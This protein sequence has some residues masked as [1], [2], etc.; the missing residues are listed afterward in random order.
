[1][2]VNFPRDLNFGQKAEICVYETLRQA[3]LWAVIRNKDAGQDIDAF[4]RDRTH[5][6]EVKNEEKWPL[7]NVCVEVSQGK[8]KRPSGIVTSRSTVYVHTFTEYVVVYVTAEMR[9]FL[10]QNWW[11]KNLTVQEFHNSDNHARGHVVPIDLIRQEP[12]CEVCTLD[13]L[14]N[15]DV[16]LG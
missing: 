2:G 6:L 7:I 3:K 16:F 9:V 12:W 4:I 10:Q 5:R 8:D 1:M 15:S 14:P 13:E 11:E